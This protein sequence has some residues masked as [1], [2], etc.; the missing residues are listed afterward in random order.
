MHLIHGCTTHIDNDTIDTKDR[1]GITH[2]FGETISKDDI[3]NAYVN[4]NKQAHTEVEM[5]NSSKG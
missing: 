1:L 2:H 3:F 4:N 5:L